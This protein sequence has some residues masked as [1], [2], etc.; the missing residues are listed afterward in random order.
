MSDRGQT[1]AYVGEFVHQLDARNR[2]TV[3]SSW[4]VAGDDGSYYLAWPHPEG[5][6]VVYPP[7]MQDELLAKAKDVR[8]SDVRSQATLRKIFGR[9]F[10]FGCDKQ[11]RILIPDPLK[12]HASI[13]K[14][15]SLIGLG[16]YFQIWDARQRQEEDEGFNLLEAMAE[17]GI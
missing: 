12:Q 3:P 17:M 15:V 10:K 2:V 11:G 7:H 6:L 4:R 13:E 5:C 14:Q 9:A 1:M 8:M 16:H